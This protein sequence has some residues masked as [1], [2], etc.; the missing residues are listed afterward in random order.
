MEVPTKKEA[1]DT[2]Y[3]DVMT[4]FLYGGMIYIGLKNWRRAMD[5]L[6]YV[7][8]SFSELGYDTDRICHRLL[9]IRAL[10][11]LQYRSRPIKNIH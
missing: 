7:C 8:L 1:K 2:N 6:T 3:Q 4:Y 10:L 5:F 11:A 9:H